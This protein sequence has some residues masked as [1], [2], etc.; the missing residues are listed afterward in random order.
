MT[1]WGSRLRTVAAVVAGVITA[2]AL[3][4]STAG[5]WAITVVFDENDVADIAVDTVR[6]PSV[7]D[8][9]ARTIVDDALA[10][11]GAAEAFGEAERD[12]LTDEVADLLAQPVVG[13]VVRDVVVAAHRGAMY[14]LTDGPVTPWVSVEGDAVVVNV[15]PL[16]ATVLELVTDLDLPPLAVEDD[17]AAQIAVIEATLGVDL[18][19]DAGQV[20]LFRS[21]TLEDAGG[22]VDLAR[23]ILTALTGL[24]VLVSS[25]ALVGAA[26]T[27]LAARARRR[28]AALVLAGVVV[29]C[30]LTMVVVSRVVA[31]SGAIVSDPVLSAVIH[32]AIEQ[33]ASSLD[34]VLWWTIGICA[35]V[36][37]VVATVRR[38]PPAVTGPVEEG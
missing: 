4:A 31:G 2:L 36:A 19:T 6:D 24:V 33:A 1:T 37:V 32:G 8:A 15:L 9:V 5:W 29:G 25:A 23:E 35:V 22:W 7:V 11:L 26:L 20:V 12:L 28:A 30:L 27:L 21:D 3:V 16:W 14:L 38:R 34:R 10:L 17:P 18:G 13:D